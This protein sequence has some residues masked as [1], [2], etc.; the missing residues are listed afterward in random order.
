[1]EL[2]GYSEE[3]LLLNP[4]RPLIDFFF[5]AKEI[6][7]P[8][9]HNP[10]LIQIISGYLTTKD[11][12]NFSLTCRNLRKLTNRTPQLIYFSTLL[13]IA[14]KRFGY[15]TVAYLKAKE[16][17]MMDK[18]GL[19]G[20]FQTSEEAFDAFKISLNCKPLVL[21]SVVKI[22]GSHDYINALWLASR[23]KDNDLLDVLLKK[24][25]SVSW[26]CFNKSCTNCFSNG[27]L[28]NTYPEDFFVAIIP[29]VKPLGVKFLNYAISMNFSIETIKKLLELG[30]QPDAKSCVLASK[31]QAVSK[32]LNSYLI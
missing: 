29:K 5:G 20:I 13:K 30:V 25:G 1:M 31:N 11:L 2:S 12:I 10:K 17:A 22:S 21:I 16:Y 18:K 6:R 9:I 28:P 4:F 27:I 8:P 7:L 26:S 19:I 3:S 24:K 23:R 15:S 32:L 14:R